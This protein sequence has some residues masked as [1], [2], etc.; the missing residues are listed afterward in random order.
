MYCIS[1]QWLLF[2]Q[3][4]RLFS[5][6]VSIILHEETCTRKADQ[7]DPD[8][9]FREGTDFCHYFLWY[10]I[11]VQNVFMIYHIHHGASDPRIFPL[12][13]IS[14]LIRRYKLRIFI[15]STSSCMCPPV[16]P[17][18]LVHKHR[19]RWGAFTIHL[20][21]LKI[22]LPIQGN[23]TSWCRVW[24]EEAVPGISTIQ[25][26]RTMHSNI[27]LLFITHTPLSTLPPPLHTLQMV[28]FFFQYSAIKK[29]PNTCLSA[30]WSTALVDTPNTRIQTQL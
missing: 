8:F 26:F 30:A 5:P 6:K 20:S 22:Q 21:S 29:T 14:A 18:N 9:Y 24:N 23:E 4:V 25:Y 11:Y 7:G 19:R 13:L 2:K 16:G 28:C 17:K 1:Y 3:T 10:N 15:C 27:T 12:N